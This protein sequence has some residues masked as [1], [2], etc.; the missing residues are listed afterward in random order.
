ME[1]QINM[2]PFSQ[3]ALKLI[4]AVGKTLDFS[5][6]IHYLCTLFLKNLEIPLI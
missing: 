1:N 2:V 3:K 4:V 5:S 6:Q